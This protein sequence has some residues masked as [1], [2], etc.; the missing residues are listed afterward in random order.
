MRWND[1]S[2]LV[3]N[4]CDKQKLSAKQK[5]I[6]ILQTI[7]EIY[8]KSPLSFSVDI[9]LY[10]D[11]PYYCDTLVFDGK[12]FTAVHAAKFV[13]VL[14]KK[15]ITLGRAYPIRL[16]Q[17]HVINAPTMIEKLV[18]IVKAYMHQKIRNRVS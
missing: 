9:R 6:H 13:S 10:E 11:S 1:V 18:S 3:R 5:L 8:F 4:E 7:F 16:N 2:W 14:L 17:I 12:N 15:L